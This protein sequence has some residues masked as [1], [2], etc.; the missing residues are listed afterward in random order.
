[1]QLKCILS[2]YTFI[3]FFG[4]IG[5]FVIP[6]LIVYYAI[7]PFTKFPQDTFQKYASY[8]YKLFYFITPK[9][10]TDIKI[11]KD[12][13]KSAI[14]VSTHQASLD[15]PLLGIF[16]ER[17]LTITNIN[18]KYVPFI[19]YIGKL[20]GVRYLNKSNIDEVQ[21]IF[22]EF[23]EMLNLDRNIL[24]F[25]EGTRGDGQKLARFK[26]GA[27]RLAFKTNKP[28]V[29]IILDG[30]H[31]IVS[32]GSFCF[33]DTKKHTIKVRMLKPIYPSDFENENKMLKYV[34]NLMEYKNNE[35]IW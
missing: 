25:P 17:Y 9:I 1:M 19:N 30:S 21:S 14:Y 27:F 26:H 16:I 13:P 4:L 2:S 8:I 12:L 23:E 33:N 5:L 6:S 24:L 35:D 20:I 18:V 34:Q 7:Y 31:K 22:K 15:Y 32:K 29:P 11:S 28:I 3:L 10:Y